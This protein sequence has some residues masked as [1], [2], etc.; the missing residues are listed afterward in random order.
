MEK[1]RRN[2]FFMRLLKGVII[3]ITAILPGASGSL[4]A[5]AMGVYRP[6]IDAVVGFFKAV[7]KNIAFLLPL[8]IGGV[9]GLFLTSRLVEWLIL[10]WHTPLMYI[11]I[12]LVLGGVPSLMKE[13]NQFGFKKRYLWGTLFGIALIFLFAAGEKLFVAGGV[14]SFNGW[15]AMLAGAVIALG[16]VLPGISTSFILMY[17]GLY[18]PL[19]A[20]L[21]RFNI[22]MMICAGI[23]AGLT[24]LAT[25]SLVKR[26]FD[27]HHGYAYYAVLGLL[28]GSVVLIF[29]GFSWSWA[30]LFYLVLFIGGFAATYFICKM[31][32]AEEAQ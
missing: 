23:G 1:E 11:L 4:I 2:S 10:N 25:V 8:G 7:R 18:E 21:N 13:A 31:P 15:T 30:Q 24:V 16:M 5:V 17:M 19:L 12:G 32:V 26:M 27:R 20:A 3:G 29:P 14:W 28:A 6:V 22:P 9:I